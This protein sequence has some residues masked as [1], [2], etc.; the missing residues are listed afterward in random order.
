MRMMI[1]GA[2]ALVALLTSQVPEFLQQ[3]RQRLGGAADELRTVVRHFDEDSRRSGY[4]RHDALQLM[5]RNPERLIRDQALRMEEN[6]SR[7]DRLN[8]QQEA[9]SEG[10]TLEAFFAVLANY[11]P[12]LVE[13]TYDNFTPA[14]PLTFTSLMFALLGFVTS[15]GVLS[16]FGTVFR[17]SRKTEA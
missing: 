8:Q 7:L 14:L 16:M 12:P 6:V 9:L 15:F 13:K 1:I 17:G 3:Y 2:S 11:D 10:V 5:K 4:Q